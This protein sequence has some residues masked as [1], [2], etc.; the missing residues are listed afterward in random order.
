MIKLYDLNELIDINFKGYQ[1]A[2]QYFRAEQFGSTDDAI[3][4]YTKQAGYKVSNNGVIYREI[5]R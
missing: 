2:M 3:Y 5:K 4:R 1:K